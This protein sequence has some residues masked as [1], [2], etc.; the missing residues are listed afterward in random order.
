LLG[1]R[2]ILRYGLVDRIIVQDGAIELLAVLAALQIWNLILLDF[3]A[4]GF[5]RS[6]VAGGALV[7]AFG[8]PVLGFL[9]SHIEV[10]GLQIVRTALARSGHSEH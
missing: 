9:A 6:L 7:A 5:E 1:G 3:G 8:G 4:I 2:G 10:H